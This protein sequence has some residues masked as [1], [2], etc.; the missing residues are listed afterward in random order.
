MLCPILGLAASLNRSA[1]LYA[2]R[3]P[4]TQSKVQKHTHRLQNNP[5]TKPIQNANLNFPADIKVIK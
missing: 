5:A 4:H 3:F 1:A 2:V